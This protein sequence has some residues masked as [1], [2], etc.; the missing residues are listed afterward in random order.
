MKQNVLRHT[1][2]RLEMKKTSTSEQAA[3]PQKNAANQIAGTPAGTVMTP[4]YVTTVAQLAYV[5]G[6]P[7]VNN[8]NR[9]LGIK[10]LPGPGRVGGV[11]PAS[12]PG[13]VSMLTDYISAEEQFVT[14]PNQDTVYGAGYQHTDTI[15]VVI[16]VPDFDN[17]FY[18]YQIADARTNSFGKIGKQYRTKPGFY[19]LVGPN[20]KGAIPAGITGV[21]HSPTDL[22]AIFPRVFQDDTPEDKAVIQP[23]LSQITVYP[24]SEFDGKMK[25]M[26]WKSTPSFPAPPSTGGETKWVIPEKS[27]MSYRS[28]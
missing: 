7:L 16:Q 15:P 8:L 5:W 23:L 28:S 13:H 17:R 12:P 19:A 10:D 26:D 25:T 9:A 2:G 21:I 27:S 6:W 14:C 4:E 18:T 11:I 22:V 20:W 3:S 24:L 1:G